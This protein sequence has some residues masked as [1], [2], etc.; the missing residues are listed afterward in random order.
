MALSLCVIGSSN[1]DHVFNVA[2]FPRPG[3]TLRADN[4]QLVYGGK[5]ANQAVA[6]LKSGANVQFISAVG[7]D[8]AGIA[9]R[10]DFASL[11]MQVDTI[12]IHPDLPT[13]LA[14][15]QVSVQ[16]E[17]SIVIVAGANESVNSETISQ[18]QQTIMQAE[19]VLMQLETPLEGICKAAEIANK[20]DKKVILNPAPAKALPDDLLKNLWMITPNESE[21][22]LLTGIEVKTITDAKSAAEKLREKGVSEV[23]ITLG[24]N[25]VYHQNTISEKHYPAF[26]VTAKD[27]TAAGDTFNGALAAA[28]LERQSLDKAIRFAQAT[29]ALSVQVAGAQPSIPSRKEIE[30]F[31]T[32]C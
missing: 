31:L 5:G 8:S 24:S 22:A 19:M 23:I 16:G 15:I 30:T 20:V 21:A 17:N 4:Y 26:Q 2:H 3:E 9:M 6:A 32:S 14:A 10:Q 18:Y 11:G 12:Q 1:L 28:L 29:A 25:G 7:N 13:G 27:T